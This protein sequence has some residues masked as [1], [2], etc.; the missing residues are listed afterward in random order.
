LAEFFFHGNAL[1][2]FEDGIFD[3]FKSD[4]QDIFYLEPGNEDRLNF[5]KNV[6]KV[7]P[8]DQIDLNRRVEILYQ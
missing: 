7:T 8:I 2:A 3:V 4:N 6:Y 5:L 1:K